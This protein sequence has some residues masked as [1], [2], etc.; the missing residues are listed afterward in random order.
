MNYTEDE[1]T[2]PE[3]PNESLPERAPEEGRPGWLI[4]LCIL[5]FIGS[6][7]SCI[8][9]FF[10]TAFYAYLPD[11]FENTREMM[12]QYGASAESA[13]AMALQPK[14]YYLLLTLLFA[15]SVT[16]AALMLALRKIGF[17]LYTIAQACLLVVPVL[18]VHQAFSFGDL[19]FTF[20]FVTLYATFLKQM[21]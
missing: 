6:G 16:G 3:T 15:A 7:L 5:T 17:H 13:A 19:L 18:F 8:G 12:E 11:I 4:F 20:A 9:Y 14:A 1:N 21:H 2:F 10:F